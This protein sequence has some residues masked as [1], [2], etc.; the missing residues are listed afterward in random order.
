MADIRMGS[1]HSQQHD[2]NLALYFNQPDPIYCTTLVS[3]ND[4]NDGEL[5]IPSGDSQP[6]LPFHFEETM[7]DIQ[8]SI[9]RR[10]SDTHLSSL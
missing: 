4:L 8:R 7:S 2:P 1:C 10:F 9:Q 6:L 3:D 5:T